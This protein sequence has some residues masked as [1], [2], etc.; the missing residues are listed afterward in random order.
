L[1]GRF[2]IRTI[3]TILGL[4]SAA[5]TFFMPTAVF[6]G[7]YYTLGARVAQGLFLGIMEYKVFRYC[8]RGQLSGYWC[9]HIKGKAHFKFIL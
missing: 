3:F 4:L 1:V 6:W 9:L 7:F 8:I 5:A 2:G